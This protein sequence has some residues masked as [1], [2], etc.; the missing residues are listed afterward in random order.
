LFGKE[1]QGFYFYAYQLK[2]TALTGE[3]L[4]T[5]K[6]GKTKNKTQKMRVPAFNKNR[7][8]KFIFTGT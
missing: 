4:V 1:K 6:E 2:R 8:W 3:I 5:K 7:C